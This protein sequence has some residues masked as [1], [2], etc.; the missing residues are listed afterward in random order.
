MKK[1]LE[2][3]GIVLQLIYSADKKQEDYY[4]TTQLLLYINYFFIFIYITLYEMFSH[5]ARIVLVCV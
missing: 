1:I 2:Y 5:I 4:Y 3:I